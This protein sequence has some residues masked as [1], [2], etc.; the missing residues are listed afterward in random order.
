MRAGGIVLCGGRSRRMGRSKA[1]LPFGHE[2]LLA[3]MLRLLGEVVEPLLVVAVP[4]QTLPDLPAGTEVVHDRDEGKGPLEGLYCGLNHWADRVTVAYVT[5]CDAPLLEPALVQY[6]LG[7]LGD[8]DVVVPIE[9]GFYHPLAAVY[10]TALAGTIA[11]LLDQGQSRM[12]S[13]YE[14]VSTALDRRGPAA[15]R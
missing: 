4:G 11:R 8:H 6:M 9:E 5:G 1:W 2:K 12:I 3:R 15:D 14:Q 7:Q 13:F 10:R